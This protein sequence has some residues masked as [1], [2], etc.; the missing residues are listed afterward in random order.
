MFGKTITS[1]SIVILYYFLVSRI[2]YIS[3][4]YPRCFLFFRRTNRILPYCLYIV[5]VYVSRVRNPNLLS[6][7]VPIY[8][9]RLAVIRRISPLRYFRLTTIPRHIVV[10]SNENC[11]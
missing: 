10:E 2:I 11:I 8:P 6:L 7:V 9:G 5:L 3:Y 4:S 1:G